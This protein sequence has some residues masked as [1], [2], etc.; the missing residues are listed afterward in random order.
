MFALEFPFFPLLL[1]SP[2]KADEWSDTGHCREQEMIC[3]IAVCIEGEPAPGHFPQCEI[4]AGPILVQQRRQVAMGNQF[5]EK[6]QQLFVWSGD[7][8]ICAFIM[9]FRCRYSQ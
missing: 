3:A 5:D 2:P 9:L 4:I 1:K 7:D 8:R 6:F